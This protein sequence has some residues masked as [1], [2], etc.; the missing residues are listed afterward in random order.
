MPAGFMVGRV[1]EAAGEGGMM[2]QV[3]GGHVMGITPFHS[4]GTVEF[5]NKNPRLLQYYVCKVEMVAI[6]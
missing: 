4:L 6:T 3:W 1:D 5:R 2:F